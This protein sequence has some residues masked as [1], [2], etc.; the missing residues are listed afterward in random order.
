[1]KKLFFILNLLLSTNALAEDAISKMMRVQSGCE[2]LKLGLY[3]NIN[4]NAPNRNLWFAGIN[5]GFLE[6]ISEKLQDDDKFCKPRGV[7]TSALAN[8][9]YNRLQ[10]EQ[11]YGD[12]KKC[13]AISFIE[14][15]LV[16][17]Y[18]CK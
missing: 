14:K 13:S 7:D 6:A 4:S 1:M 15:V 16:E 9:L 10:D 18:P 3:Q 17:T 5:W 12:I 11:L 2:N 8:L